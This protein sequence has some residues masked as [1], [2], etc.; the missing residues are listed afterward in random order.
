M[1]FLKFIVL[2]LLVVMSLIKRSRNKN[3]RHSNKS[4]SHSR[5]FKVLEKYGQPSVRILHAGQ[6]SQY[7]FP[8]P[9]Q[10]H[11]VMLLRK[12]EGARFLCL[13]FVT[14]YDYTDKY[15]YD[16]VHEIFSFLGDQIFCLN[17]HSV[18]KVSVGGDDMTVKIE[19][20]NN[21]GDKNIEYNLK[22][23]ADA[24]AIKALGALFKKE[25]EKFNVAIIK[26]ITQEGI[27]NL[28]NEK[29]DQ[30]ELTESVKNNPK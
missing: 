20:F 29:K 25:V 30:R 19:L 16:N 3:N 10:S 12:E 21:Y 24:K 13:K 23:E 9:E 6:S 4:R 14:P 1:K 17:K 26:S 7:N 2:L 18:E 28:A 27:R 22:F 8:A 15:F 5:D 11:K